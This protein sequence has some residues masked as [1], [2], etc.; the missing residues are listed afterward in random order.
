MRQSFRSSG[1]AFC[2]L[3][4]LLLSCSSRALAASVSICVWPL[5]LRC[6]LDGLLSV[7]FWHR[8]RIACSNT[9]M[10]TSQRI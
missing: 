8:L 7:A 5:P 9:S 4:Y 10:Q 1:N 6:P 2:E 3:Q